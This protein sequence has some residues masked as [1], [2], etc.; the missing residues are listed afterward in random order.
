M[1]NMASVKD[2]LSFKLGLAFIVI[3]LILGIGLS[4]AQ[5][6]SGFERTKN[7]LSTEVD[8]LLNVS[9]RPASQSLYFL[10]EDF[11][12]ELLK[13]LLAT[14]Y[15]TQAWIEDKDGK[16][17]ASQEVEERLVI[18][19]LFQLFIETPLED[20]TVRLHFEDFELGTLHIRVN[21]ALAYAPFIDQIIFTFF[22][23]MAGTLGAV[24]LLLYVFYV[25]VGK[26]MSIVTAHI[27]ELQL[28]SPSTQGIPPVKSHLSDE[29]GL[30]VITIN[31]Y[32][33]D[34][35]KT[36]SGRIKAEEQLSQLNAELEARVN[37]RTAELRKTN[38]ELQSEIGEREI[39]E[40]NMHKA[41]IRAEDANKAKSEFLATMSHEIRTPMNAVIGM[42]QLTLQTDVTSKQ[43]NYLEKID[44]SAQSLLAIIN[45][46]LDFSKIEA[47][48]LEMECIPFQLEDVLDNLTGIVGVKA[49]QKGLE[50]LFNVA[51]NTPT[52]LTG[53]PLRLGQVLINLAG[54]AVKFTEL[55]EIEISVKPLGV[56][57]EAVETIQYETVTENQIRLE[58]TV[59]D[60]GIG[61]TQ[62][63]Q[64]SLFK[65]FTQADSSTTRKYGGT[66]LGLAICKQIVALM[67]GDLN[68]HSEPQVGSR[69]VFT[70]I[71]LSAPS[72]SQAFEYTVK[73]ESFQREAAEYL[74]GMRVLV[75]D[76]NAAA[77]DIL[78]EML[79]SFGCEVATA[80]SGEQAIPM[81][82]AAIEQNAAFKLLVLDWN[83]PEMNGVEVASRVRSDHLSTPTSN[84]IMVSAYQQA[85]ILNDKDKSVVDAFLCKPV[86]ASALLDTM[87]ETM[88]GIARKQTT[89]DYMQQARSE[90]VAK[91]YGAKVLLVEDNEFNQEVACD[92]LRNAHMQVDVAANG[93][94]ALKM[95]DENTYDGI[96]MDIQMPVMDGFEACRILRR[97]K[98][99]GH[100]PVIA[101]TANAMAGD[102]EK[103]LAAGMNSYISKPIK[104][105]DM[106]T[107]LAQWISPSITLPAPDNVDSPDEREVVLPDI[108]GIDI[109]KGL[110]YLEGN[111]TLYRRMLA[112]FYSNQ[113]HFVNDMRVVLESG[114]D[115]AAIRLAHS[116][117]SVAGSIGLDVIAEAAK[118]LEQACSNG[119]ET[120]VIE[121][122]LKTIELA[123][124]PIL[125][126]LKSF[127]ANDDRLLKE[128]LA[129]GD[130]DIKKL[131]PEFH[132]LVQLL[133]ECDT[134]ARTLFETIVQKMPSDE[135]L[136]SELETLQ[137]QISSYDYE[138][139][140]ITL[141][142]LILRLGLELD[143]V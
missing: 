82:D 41:Q 86:S 46:I 38:Q 11:A 132:Q 66:G 140:A 109:N 71:F 124:S 90:V 4:T 16:V 33:A 40:Q 25:Q 87:M 95:L 84:I 99:F 122:R 2:N 20:S 114:D 129:V 57:K 133:L 77:R 26:P 128:T 101:M 97:D 70:A 91:L 19:D 42:S 6:V 24:L 61:L 126:K 17:F 142:L 102:K 8:A 51:P 73:D 28:D 65:P 15:L 39:A 75:V 31:T 121:A 134:E 108:S 68:V 78:R 117:K 18:L 83:M 76:D 130:F 21:K 93:E 125:T 104:V 135:S 60:T 138:K 81:I 52:T 80:I 14:N 12:N 50:F 56:E 88:G 5:L 113:K 3:A 34:M 63:Q 141:N 7:K 13:G 92:L 111:R 137:L 1:I 59:R 48:E 139:A 64:V 98:R 100:L 136:S 47:G 45:D 105:K 58:F 115:Q 85:E 123:L 23:T 127:L 32:I 37:E 27:K 62:S 67:E 44:R 29:I 35:E 107:T 53:D 43:R 69:F 106:F 72:S 96:L 94:D 9:E 116:L 30:L 74:K 118:A 36:L 131:A 110:A 55:G 120:Q 112:L 49:Q 10:T 54:N 103:C 79:V 119:S 143:I 89:N 22:I